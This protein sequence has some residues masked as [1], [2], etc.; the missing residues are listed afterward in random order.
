M[1]S[2]SA[3]VAA[4]NIQSSQRTRKHHQQNQEPKQAPIKKC[5]FNE[6]SFKIKPFRQTIVQNEQPKTTSGPLKPRAYRPQ[7][8]QSNQI[9]KNVPITVLN[10]PDTTNT[11]GYELQKVPSQKEMTRS[12]THDSMDRPGSQVII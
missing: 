8:Q 1:G 2:C 11:A 7:P 9:G 5:V 4:I 6:F 10:A 3:E 12:P